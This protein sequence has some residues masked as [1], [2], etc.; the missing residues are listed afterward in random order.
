MKIRNG[1]VSNSSSSS[2]VVKAKSSMEAYYKMLKAYNE[3]QNASWGCDGRSDDKFINT[4]NIDFNGGIFIPYTCNY[5]TYIYPSDNGECHVETCNN[6]D[7]SDIILRYVDED[8]EYKYWEDVTTPFTDV[9]TNKI[10]TAKAFYDDV[11]SGDDMISED[12]MDDDDPKRP[13]RLVIEYEDVQDIESALDEVKRQ[14]SAGYTQGYEPRW[15]IE[16]D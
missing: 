5:E 9:T 3:D 2:F 10:K 15:Y 11:I 1:F 6:H 7:W 4:H 13:G 16:E 12:N 8:G 14:I